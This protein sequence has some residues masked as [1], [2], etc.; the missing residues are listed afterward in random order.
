MMESSVFLFPPAVTRALFPFPR[1]LSGLLGVCHLNFKMEVLQSC[2]SC[3]KQMRDKEQRQM[4][5]EE[6]TRSHS[7]RLQE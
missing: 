4:T 1:S 3:K 6:M 2:P 7:K 5:R